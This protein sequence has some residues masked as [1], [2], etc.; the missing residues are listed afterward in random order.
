MR[1][2]VTGSK[3]QLGRVLLEKLEPTHEVLGLDL[4]ESDVTDAAALMQT[5]SE[6]SPEF[7][8]HGAA[9]TKVDYCAE[10][11]DVALK[12]NGYGTRNIALACQA[13]NIP[14][15]YVST[16]EVFDGTNPATYLEY[17]MT[18]AINP[19][20]YSKVVGERIIR[21]LVPRH[22][23]VRTSWLFGHG[24]R[25][26]IHAILE[27]AQQGKPLRVVVNEVATPTYVND[28][29]D[30]LISLMQTQKY[31]IYHLVNEGRASRWEFARYVLDI[32]GFKAVD[33]ARISSYEYQRA[34]TPPEYAVLRNF[35][36][37]NDGI[38]LRPWQEAVY[39]FCEQEDLIASEA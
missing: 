3:G 22:Y 15:L 14:L 11:P 26:F 7:V 24:G 6:F 31:G 13:L 37:A 29:A 21:D 18:N 16:N 10:N 2:I 12:I 5:F 28:F 17:D 19:Y 8:I 38:K 4:P 34:S 27:R 1:I 36:A 32:T 39:T 9:L 23:I 30:A 25:N 20:G 35:A 33:I